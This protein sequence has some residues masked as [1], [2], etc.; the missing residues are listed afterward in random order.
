[1][2]YTTMVEIGTIPTQKKKTYDGCHAA[3]SLYP[4]RLPSALRVQRL[5]A[6]AIALTPPRPAYVAREARE[7]RVRREPARLACADEASGHCT[8]PVDE[9][10]D[11][12]NRPA[13]EAFM[14]ANPSCAEC[15]SVEIEWVSTSI[16]CSLC[17]D[18]ASVHR[19]LGT[20]VS[21]LRSLSGTT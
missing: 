4:R 2:F 14:Q 18:C 12:A 15:A 5:H 6:T 19:R 17:V 9:L 10:V 1:M 16:G 20:D 7:S 3:F 8:L 13:L 11:E 21:R